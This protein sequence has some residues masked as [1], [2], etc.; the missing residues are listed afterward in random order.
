MSNLHTELRPEPRGRIAM[1]ECSRIVE[2]LSEYL[3]RDLPAETC[4]R[5]DEHLRKC[6]TCGKAAQGLRTTVQLCRE[7]R[8]ASQPGPLP[9]AKHDEMK[10]A[11]ETTL[12]GMRKPD[13]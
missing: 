4:A 6:S 5:I 13:A 7:Y 9:A 8:A 12:A 11:L 2:M 10:R 3:D 1:A